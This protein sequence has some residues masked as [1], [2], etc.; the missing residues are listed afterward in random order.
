MTT[1]E[2]PDKAYFRVRKYPWYVWLATVLWVALIGFLVQNATASAQELEPRAAAIFWVSTVVVV[3][4]GL[5]IAFVRSR[6]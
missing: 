6:R 2:S 5:V 3:L 1:Q 4:A